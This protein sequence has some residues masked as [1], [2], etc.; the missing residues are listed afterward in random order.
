MNV[1]ENVDGIDN[2]FVLEKSGVEISGKLL[3]GRVIS[4]YEIS[5][6]KVLDF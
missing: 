4:G 5:K 1:S 3:G 2:L 6:G